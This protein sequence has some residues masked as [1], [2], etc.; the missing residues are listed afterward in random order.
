MFTILPRL[1]HKL[2]NELRDLHRSHHREDQQRYLAE[3]PHLCSELLSSSVVPDVIVIREDASTEAQD[4]A[5]TW[6]QRGV[7]VY[8]CGEKDM[9]L[10][11]NSVSPQSILARVPFHQEHPIGARCIVLDGV[12]DPGNVGTIIRCA[13]WFGMTDVVLGDGCADLYNPKTI[14]STAGAAFRINVV[15]HQ[16]LVHVLSNLTSHTVIATVP[17]NGEPPTILADESSFALVIG[18]EAHGISADIL[19]VCSLSVCI[20][21]GNG[22]ESLNA[23]MAAAILAYEARIQR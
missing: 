15:R 9:L 20:P 13:A 12:A 10:A 19:D 14:R 7:H 21:G 5:H 11:S 1:P 2:R 22:T 6:L 16:Q 4:I 8:V 18:S 23:A 3:G 17:R